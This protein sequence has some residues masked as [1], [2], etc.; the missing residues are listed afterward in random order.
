MSDDIEVKAIAAEL[1]R[2][3]VDG[4]ERRPFFVIQG[5]SIAEDPYEEIVQVVVDAALGSR[6]D[7]RAAL[8]ERIQGMA[9][10]EREMGRSAVHRA[11]GLETAAQVVAGGRAF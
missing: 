11:V 8:A 6:A 4:R 1:H 5:L 10:A 3:N 2:W 9:D 7:L